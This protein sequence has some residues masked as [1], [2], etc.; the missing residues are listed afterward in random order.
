MKFFALFA[1]V[2]TTEK[3]VLF[4]RENYFSIYAI[5]HPWQTWSPHLTD[6]KLGFCNFAFVGEMPELKQI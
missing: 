6:N 3:N 5:C 4:F 2:S 1:R